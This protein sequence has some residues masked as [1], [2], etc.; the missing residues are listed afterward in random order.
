MILACGTHKSRVDPVH[1]VRVALQAGAS[2]VQIHLRQPGKAR[3]G[4]RKRFVQRLSGPRGASRICGRCEGRPLESVGIP[5]SRPCPECLLD[6]SH[7][8]ASAPVSMRRAVSRILQDL[9]QSTGAGFT[10]T[11]NSPL[12]TKTSRVRW[13]AGHS[14]RC[15]S[16]GWPIRFRTIAPLFNREPVGARTPAQGC[17][18][19]LQ[20]DANAN[21]VTNGQ[22]SM[23]AP[24]TA[25]DVAPRASPAFAVPSIRRQQHLPHAWRRTH[26]RCSGSRRC[27][28]PRRVRGHRALRGYGGRARPSGSCRLR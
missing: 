14:S 13:C 9:S 1:K 25:A 6:F 19:G 7:A 11:A 26:R 24:A 20:R 8:S 16:S 23:R 3:P 22:L 17:R 5:A 10:M 4:C 12:R 21:P 28:P 15:R 2:P 18:C 27:R